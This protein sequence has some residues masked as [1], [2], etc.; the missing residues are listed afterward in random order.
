MIERNRLDL[1]FGPVGNTAGIM[2]GMVGFIMGI[3]QQSYFA[4]FPIFI[5]AFVGFSSTFCF[6]DFGNKKIKFVNKFFG[7][8]PIGK[9]IT[10]EDDMTFSL[11][12][13]S[14]A[15]KS[16]SLSNRTLSFDNT[17]FRVFLLDK[18][19][20]KIMPIKKFKTR[21]KAENYLTLLLEKL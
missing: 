5:G 4:I 8:F 17:D 20:K 16:H 15:W 18:N 19:G 13:S 12:K 10:I 9:W 3:I 14:S 11:Q 6:V 7:L 2:L 21:D 1:W